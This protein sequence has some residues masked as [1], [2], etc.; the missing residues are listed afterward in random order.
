MA[1][2][3]NEDFDEL[4]RQYSSDSAD[5]DLEI[6]NFNEGGPLT[7]RNA[8]SQSFIPRKLLARSFTEVSFQLDVGE[9]GLVEYDPDGAPNGWHIVKRIK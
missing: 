4:Q 3:E 9:I 1:T 6:G 7:A 2:A 5:Q 8:L